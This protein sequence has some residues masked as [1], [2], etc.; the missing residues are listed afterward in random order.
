MKDNKFILRTHKLSL[1]WPLYFS[2]LYE[3]LNGSAHVGTRFLKVKSNE[4]IDYLIDMQV[5]TLIALM[6]FK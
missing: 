1:H 5:L 3:V 2:M 6:K 4:E